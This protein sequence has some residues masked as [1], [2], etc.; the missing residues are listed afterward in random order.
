MPNPSVKNIPLVIDSLYQHCH[1]SVVSKAY[2]IY[3]FWR[4]ESF[5]DE[6]A[7]HSITKKNLHLRIKTSIKEQKVEAKA[8]R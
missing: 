6:L 3:K 8:R 2:L 1:D 4:K 7:H 5:V